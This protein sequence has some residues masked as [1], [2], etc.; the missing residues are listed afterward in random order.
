MKR[1]NILKCINDVGTYKEQYS[2]HYWSHKILMVFE[3]TGK[4]NVFEFKLV[5][6]K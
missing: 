1:S 3:C 5:Q 2:C 6:E 4:C